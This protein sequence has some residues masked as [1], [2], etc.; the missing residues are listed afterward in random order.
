MYYY[1][2]VMNR[3]VVDNRIKSKLNRKLDTRSIARYIANP[4]GYGLSMISYV[5]ED[6]FLLWN[7]SNIRQDETH[8]QINL[9]RNSN[10]EGISHSAWKL[11]RE[12]DINSDIPNE[13][14]D[15]LI[16]S[17]CGENAIAQPVPDPKLS[18]IEKYGIGYRPRQTMFRDVKNARRILVSKLNDILAGTRLNTTF[19]GWDIHITAR[20]Y[21]ETINWYE[22]E[23][24][25]PV[26]KKSIRYNDTI[27]PIFNVAGVAE[28]YKLQN[29]ADGSIIQVKSNQNDVTQL[30][31]Y[32]GSIDD[33]ELIMEANDTIRIRNS[34][35]TDDTNPTLSSELRLLLNTLKN[36]VFE[37]TSTW[38]EIFFELLKYAY[39]E[40]KQLDWAFKTSYLYIEKEE[41]DLIE[42]NGFK[43]DNSK[44]IRLHER[45]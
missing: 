19:A 36:N 5:S 35:F 22:V 1:Y 16:D 34:L 25:D 42:F 11:M 8:L 18:D 44:S 31:K 32:K 39:L 7:L 41:D 14:S 37:N 43:P 15:K 2:W 29:L 12:G 26:T 21:I 30:W 20:A 9:S 40:Q 33:F 13:I 28:L 3:T 10:P 38:N 45:G 23:Y 24:T 27:K 4:R 17:L 6:S